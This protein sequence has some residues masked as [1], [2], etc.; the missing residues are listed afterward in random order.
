VSGTLSPIDIAESLLAAAAREGAT[1]AEAL[2]IGQDSALTRFAD[3]TIHQNVAETDLVANLRF[4]VG[5]R[6]GVAS[7]NRLD[8]DGRRALAERAGR[9]AR[10]QQEQPDFVSLPQP[11]PIPSVVGAFDPATAA[12][13]PEA[14]ADAVLAVVRQA[15]AAGVGASGSF[16]TSAERMAVAN[17]LDIRAE[18]EMTRAHLIVVSTAPNGETG[19]AEALAVRLADLDPVAVGREAAQRARDCCD[20]APLAAGEYEV[21]LEP[22]A[23]ADLVD[24]LASLGFSALA[25]Q[26]DRS[27]YQPGKRL[28]SDLVSIWDDGSDPAGTPMAFDFEG[29]GKQRVDLIVEGIARDIVYDS[30]TAARDG[31]RSTGHGLP[32]PNPWGPF[33]L[34]AFMAPGATVREEL[35]RGLDRGLLVTRFHYTN[36]VQPKLGI[37]TGMTRD[38]TF[39]VERGEIVGPVRN[40]RFTQS[41]L[42]ALRQVK[43]VGNERR[44]LPA[45]GGSVVVPALRIGAFDFTGA[46]E[47]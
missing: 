18:Q 24:T 13:S 21:V 9:I 47:H 16:A 4:V 34:N 14:R 1:Q 39:L 3:G 25:V 8:E 20:P 7:S 45:P 40:L 30:A 35:I 6:I 5:K 29:V 38:G 10:L 41:Y 26:E 19:Y 27:F 31:R 43:A 44:L 33:A 36:P 28:G 23:V 12:A 17:S 32:A 11:G 46:A 2:V 22:Y 15:G 42:E 37:V